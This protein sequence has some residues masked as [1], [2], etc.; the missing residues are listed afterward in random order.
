MLLGT[1]VLALLTWICFR[2]NL[3]IAT[4]IP[5]FMVIVVLLSLSGRTF[6]LSPS[7]LLLRHA[8]ITLLARRFSASR[9]TLRKIS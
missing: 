9:S 1:A 2:L 7:P 5:I 6:R 8:W 4:T 3:D